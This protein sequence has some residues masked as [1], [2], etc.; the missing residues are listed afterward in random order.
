MTYTLHK[1]D[2]PAD[3]QTTDMV[4]VDTETTGLSPLRDRLCLVQLSFGDGHAHI[5]QM[6]EGM[7]CPNLKKLSIIKN[8][9]I[10]L[11]FLNHTNELKTLKLEDQEIH[12]NQNNKT[13]SKIEINFSLYNKLDTLII[14]SSDHYPYDI[15]N[16]ATQ[17]N[18]KS[19]KRVILKRRACWKYQEIVDIGLKDITLKEFDYC[20][21]EKEKLKKYLE[22]NTNY[23]IIRVENIETLLETSNKNIQNNQ[24]ISN[25]CLDVCINWCNYRKLL[26]CQ[27]DI[28]SDNMIIMFDKLFKPEETISKKIRKVRNICVY[29]SVNKDKANIEYYLENLKGLYENY[30]ISDKKIQ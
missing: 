22:E 4:A 8:R 15:I 26:D 3:I 29:M 13:N 2:L 11:D 5:V 21:D 1:G 9:K 14:S 27:G 17:I 24:N 19:L 10:C 16:L 7:D 12:L 30:L 28:S 6:E 23:T 25:T 20:L 18:F